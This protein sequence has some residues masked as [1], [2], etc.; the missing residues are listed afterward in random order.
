M[1]IWNDGE[2]M[3]ALPEMR[4][5]GGT[6]AWV[7]VVGRI[8]QPNATSASTRPRCLSPPTEALLAKINKAAMILDPIHT[9][10][11][12]FWRA[13][14]L[15]G[16]P[17]LASHRNYRALV[18]GKHQISDAQLRAILADRNYGDNAIARILYGK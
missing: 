18:Q 4:R 16:G 14:D 1:A 3:A 5:G 6:V 15:F 17:L 12:G 7:E 10:D 9:S 13:L 2:T 11:E 8:R